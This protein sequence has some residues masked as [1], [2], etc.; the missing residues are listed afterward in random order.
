MM[1]EGL[2]DRQNLSQSAKW[3]RMGFYRRVDA[4]LH[5]A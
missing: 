3:C 5:R 1:A 4:S 2:P